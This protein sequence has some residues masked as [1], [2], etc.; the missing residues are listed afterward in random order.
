MQGCVFYV[1]FHFDFNSASLRWSWC[2]RAYT[3]CVRCVISK[4]AL[5]W[6]GERE[7]RRISK[8]KSLFFNFLCVQKVF[9]LLHKNQIE[10]LMVAGLPWRCFSY[11]SEPRQ[12]YLLYSQWDSHKPPVF[13]L[14]IFFAKSYTYFTSCQFVWICT[15]D[16]H[17]SQP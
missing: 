2:R 7:S 9:S 17:L 6:Q 16:L 8:K 15:N 3:A 10:P 1:Y 4:M 14:K 13:Y 12:C 5:R 11:F